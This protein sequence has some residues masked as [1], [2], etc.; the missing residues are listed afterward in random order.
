MSDLFSTEALEGNRQVDVTTAALQSAISGT[1]NFEAAD[2]SSPCKMLK[3]LPTSIWS[4]TVFSH[5]TPAQPFP[6]TFSQ[7]ISSLCSYQTGRIFFSGL[8]RQIGRSLTLWMAGLGAKHI[9]LTSRNAMLDEKWVEKV[10]Q[11][12][13]E[14]RLI[15]NDITNDGSRPKAC[16]RSTAPGISMSCSVTTRP[17]SSLSSLRL[18]AIACHLTCFDRYQTPSITR[19]EHSWSG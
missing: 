14:V 13:A 5:G 1:G 3:L 7:K 17:T 8:T 9:V 6:S 4:W 18:P 10:R 12:G 16:A 11:C 19:E 2:S 15:A